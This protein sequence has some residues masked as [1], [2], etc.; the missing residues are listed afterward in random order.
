MHDILTTFMAEVC[1][2]LNS[3]PLTQISYDPESTFIP[4][5]AVLLTGKVNFLLVLSESLETKDMYRAQRKHVHVL[6]YVFWKHWRQDYLQ[7]LQ[8]RHKWRKERQNLN[9]TQLCNRKSHK[10]AYSCDNR[11]L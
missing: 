8:Q 2:I 3:K 6:S 4:S 11:N 10:L 9:I 7:N 5:P 1:S